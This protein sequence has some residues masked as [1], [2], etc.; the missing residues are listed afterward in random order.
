MRALSTAKLC[1]PYAAEGV[2]FPEMLERT[3]NMLP[4]YEPEK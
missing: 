2:E 1:M 4:G 3:L